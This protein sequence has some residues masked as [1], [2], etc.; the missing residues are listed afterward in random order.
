M[1]H[2]LLICQDMRTIPLSDTW[3]PYRIREPSPFPVR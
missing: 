1:K 3:K 2:F